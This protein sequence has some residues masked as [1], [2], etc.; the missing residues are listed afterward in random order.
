MCRELEP[1]CSKLG[2]GGGIDMCIRREGGGGVDMCIRPQAG[3]K[4][5]TCK[6]TGTLVTGHMVD[7]VMIVL[8]IPE[9]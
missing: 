4:K 7:L 8:L 1:N 2:G 3:D 5:S 9:R 6:S